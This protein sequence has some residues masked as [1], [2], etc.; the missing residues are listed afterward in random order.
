[1]RN[2]YTDFSF[3]FRPSLAN[4]SGYAPADSLQQPAQV[5]AQPPQDAALG[6]VDGPDGHP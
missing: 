2:P 6:G 4:P 1:M 3:S 5:L